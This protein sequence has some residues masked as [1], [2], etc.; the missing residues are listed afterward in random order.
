MRIGKRGKTCLLVIG[1]ILAVLLL[2][3]SVVLMIPS[4]VTTAPQVQFIV[5]QDSVTPTGAAFMFINEAD[6]TMEYSMEFSVEKKTAFGWRKVMI[7]AIPSIPAVV[8]IALPRSQRNDE[9][10]WSYL[11]GS[12]RRGQYRL[13]KDIKLL[14]EEYMLAAEFTV[15]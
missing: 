5:V 3:A 14:G 6:A 2:A 11:Y 7:K 12:L 13:V 4:K 1:I 10:N 9:V 8:C 15:P